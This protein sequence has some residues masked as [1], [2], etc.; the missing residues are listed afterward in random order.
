MNTQFKL[1]IPISKVDEEKRMV[2]GVATTEAIDCQNDVV[3]YEASKIAFSNW[4]GNI[5]EMHQPVAVGK[6]IDIEYDDVNKQVIIGTKISE[7]TDGE[8]AWI[9]V[10]EGVLTGFSIGGSIKQISKEVVKDKNGKEQPVSRI[11]DYS[12]AEV[13]LVDS[14]ANPEAMFIMVKSKANGLQRV[15]EEVLSAQ[16]HK[17]NAP[18]WY[19]V[20][21]LPMEKAQALYDGSM[22]KSGVVVVDGVS[23]TIKSKGADMKKGMWDA[24]FLLNLAIELGYYIQ[25]EEYEGEDITEL[26]AALNTIKQAVVAELTEVT[27]QVESAVELAQKL[28]DLKKEK[29]MST[30]KKVIKSTSVAGGEERDAN[31]AVV[32]TAEDNGRPLNDTEE[33]AT[34]ADLKPAAEGEPTVHAEGTAAAD[35]DAAKDKQNAEGTDVAEVTDDAEVKT[36]ADDSEKS[37]TVGDLRKFTDSLISKIGDS[38]KQDLSKALGELSDE[39]EKT[40]EKAVAPLKDR[41]KQL[42]DQPAAI[43]A[44]ANYHD[45]VKGGDGSEDDAD[46]TSLLKRQDELIRDP[47]A[48]TPKE[49]M[50]LSLALRKAQSAGANLTK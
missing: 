22:K 30:D 34:E 6:A 31:A 17:F 27:P 14:P 40:I 24:S 16:L 42:E 45:V 44:K 48:G 3:D 32:T 4:L 9:K 13:S 35:A 8:N 12:L 41:I 19:Q 20:F 23:V 25:S 47:Q 29:A 18:S 43:T 33:R 2:Y 5:R 28:I 37:V 38:N 11:V 10:K 36:T 1:H 39:V 21:M 26:N 15:E 46:V 49:R 7:S 50:E